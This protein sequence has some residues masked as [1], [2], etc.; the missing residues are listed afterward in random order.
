[1]KVLVLTTW[2]N[3][4]SVEGLKRYY[5]NLEKQREY[6]AEI[7]KK[8]NVKASDWTDGTGKMY[9]MMEFESY[10]AYAKLAEDIEFHKDMVRL[11]RLVKNVK[12]KVLRPGMSVPP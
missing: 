11:F 10:G 2:E 8:Y 7:T 5:D 1:M 9:N 6:R 12:I 3:P 4:K